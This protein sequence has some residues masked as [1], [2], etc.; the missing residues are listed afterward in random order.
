MAK[1]FVQVFHDIIWK[2]LDEHGQP[3]LSN[4]YRCNRE[5][6]LFAPDLYLMGVEVLDV[7]QNDQWVE[8]HVGQEQTS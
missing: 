8:N 7:K 3:Y 2:N 5:H 1:K 4:T 6:E